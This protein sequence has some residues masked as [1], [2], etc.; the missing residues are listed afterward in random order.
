MIRRVIFILWFIPV[1]AMGQYHI[2]GKVI[3]SASKKPMG[4]ASVFLNNASVGTKTNSDGTFN[5][6]S[7]HS[8][9]YDLVVSVIGY[10]TF[11]QTI[12]VNSDVSMPEIRIAEKNI[13]LK[14]VRIG[15]DKDWDRNYALFK[16]DFLG[17]TEAAK[18]CKILNP[19]VISLHFDE[20]K[21][22]LSASSYDFII[23]ENRALGYRVKYLLSEFTR[24]YSN[25][26]FNKLYYEGSSNFEDLKGS[27]R[28]IERWKKARIQ[29]YLE[30]DAHFLR[31]II[32]DRVKDEG[33]V[34]RRLIRD[35]TSSKSSVGL[36]KPR[37][38][39]LVTT[40]LAINEYAKRTNQTG[41]YA[42]EF[43]DCLAITTT[44]KVNFKTDAVLSFLEPYAFFD[45]NGVVM[46]PRGVILEGTWGDKRIADMLPVDYEPPVQ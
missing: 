9:Y 29:A 8:G 22:I 27:K 11:R 35:T 1:V 5:I 2:T 28:D 40:P 19:E 45:N 37:A 32:A 30:S 13:A 3:D 25:A 34:V 26:L 24:A 4:D 16:E 20:D 33:F 39:T 21:F 10:K 7:V 42:I 17:K 15:P 23:I 44:G 36:F 31:S 41:Q 12:S 46:N 6:P 38:Q 14:E 18:E 43:K